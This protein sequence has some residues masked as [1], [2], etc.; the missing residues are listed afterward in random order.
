MD[1]FEERIAP[2]FAKSGLRDRA[3]EEAI[4]LPRGII[5]KWKKGKNKN[6]KF[7]VVE[8]AKYFSVSVDYL[9]GNTDD[10]AP[11]RQKE[12]PPAQGGELDN[13]LIDRL[14]QLTPDELEKVDAFVQGL[15]AARGV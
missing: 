8:I 10:P 7:Y 6:Y 15:I 2:L 14:V 9:L 4:G 1:I 5:Y 3:L 13:M 11:A 12:K